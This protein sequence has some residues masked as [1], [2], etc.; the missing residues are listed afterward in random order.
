M[1][2]ELFPTFP[3]YEPLVFVDAPF[4]LNFFEN[5]VS[6]SSPPIEDADYIKWLN[7]VEGEKSIFYRDL[8]I[9]DL[10]LL[11]QVGPTYNTH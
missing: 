1:L 5:I 7:R 11:S 2:K 9:F 3:S 4:N 6:H 8:A 10:T